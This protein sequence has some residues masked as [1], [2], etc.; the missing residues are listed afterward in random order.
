MKFLNRTFPDAEEHLRSGSNGVERHEWRFVCPF[1]LGGE[2]KENSFDMN[3]DQG[4]GRCWRQ[5]CNWVGGHVF[6]I[7][8]YLGITWDEAKKLIGSEE[9]IT[10][11]SVRAEL[12]NMKHIIDDNYRN[13]E[14]D[15]GREIFLE[16]DT[17][18]PLEDSRVKEEV[19]DWISMVRGYKVKE[20]L[21]QHDVWVP[22]QYK[23][24]EG[25]VMFIVKTNDDVAYIMYAFDEELENKTLNPTGAV[26]SRMLYNYNEVKKAKVVFV[27]EGI[28]DC[29]RVMSWGYSAVASFGVAVQPGQALLLDDLKAKE[30][31]VCFDNGAEEQA[32]KAMIAMD[33][34]LSDNKTITC[35]TLEREGADP[36]SISEE[37]FLSYYKK[38]R[39][40]NR[41]ENESL[42]GKIGKIDVKSWY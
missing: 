21:T 37:L 29:A 20:F 41:D 36:D 6:F 3:I 15:V 38:R 34:V 16:V 26:L 23:A 28:F 14:E 40:F 39:K 35:M 27:T 32:L 11:R 13:S 2:H 9:Q 33:S 22:P 30:I 10:T 4:V 42:S 25:R 1:C 18:V 24:W 17:A 8:E 31:C 7:S 19:Y 5:K 12:K